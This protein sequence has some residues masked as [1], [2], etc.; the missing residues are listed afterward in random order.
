M[1]R[2]A[3]KPRPWPTPAVARPLT[4]CHVGL[5]TGSSLAPSIDAQGYLLTTS[6]ESRVVTFGRQRPNQFVFGRQSARFRWQSG[7]RAYGH[8]RDATEWGPM[9]HRRLA[10]AGV[11]LAALV[12]VVARQVVTSAGTAMPK[13]VPFDDAA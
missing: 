6:P 1:S 7:P 8:T 9:M 3:V 5:S 11:A 12:P 4:A 2:I 10:I 13:E